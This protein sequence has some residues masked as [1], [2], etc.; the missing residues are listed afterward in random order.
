M[1][2]KYNVNN[3]FNI[4]TTD[5][6]GSTILAKYV[7][8]WMGLFSEHCHSYTTNDCNV[9]GDIH[10]CMRKYQSYNPSIKTY[11]ITRPIEERLLDFY[12]NTYGYVSNIT[13][14]NMV[15]L[16]TS[17]KLVNRYIKSYYNGLSKL[18]C[19]YG[20]CEFIQLTD[21]DIFIK[22]IS[23]KYSLKISFDRYLKDKQVEKCYYIDKYKSVELYKI[24]FNDL[25]NYDIE[26]N[27]SLFFNNQILSKIYTFYPNDVTLGK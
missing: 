12:L 27:K 6:I 15:D 18:K 21:L 13:F 1:I 24:N 3:L 14:E 9:T 17:G 10:T 11:I 16:V 5:N 23:N 2:Y 25:K 7:S 19:L 26:S 8:E 22:Q 4:V 20:E